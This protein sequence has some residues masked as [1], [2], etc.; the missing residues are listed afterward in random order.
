[1]QSVQLGSDPL[2]NLG[3]GGGGA[4]SES[5]AAS[6]YPHAPPAPSAPQ[7]PAAP[8][9]PSG[10]RR[11]REEDV[12][13]GEDGLRQL[14]AAGQWR[15]VASLG[16][17]LLSSSHPVDVLLRLRWFRITALLKLREHKAA[18]HEMSLLGDLRGQQWQYERYPALF[19]GKKGSMIPF[20]LSLLHAMMPACAG[21]HSS[22]QQRLYALLTT[23]QARLDAGDPAKPDLLLQQQQVRAPAGLSLPSC[24]TAGAA[25]TKKRPRERRWCSLSPTCAALRATTRSPSSTC[26]SS[27]TR[28]VPT[29]CLHRHRL[30]GRR[31]LRA[32]SFSRCSGGCSCR[33]ATSRGRRTPSRASSAS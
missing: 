25:P 32:G 5:R 33:W 10:A 15:A 30:Q 6:A 23:I 3:G 29:W 14:A 24:P 26:S 16:Q 9:A 12:P 11:L 22:A 8:V 17:T 2:A 31:S 1:M 18:E 7:P 4:A 28:A 20:S 21:D 13:R 27:S 19:T